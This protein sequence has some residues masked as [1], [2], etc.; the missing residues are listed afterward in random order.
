MYDRKGKSVSTL[1]QKKST[2]HFEDI[3]EI[4]P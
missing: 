1:K 4:V 3:D 2:K